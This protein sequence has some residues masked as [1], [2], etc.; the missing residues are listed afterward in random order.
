MMMPAAPSQ[1]RGERLF[2]GSGLLRVDLLYFV[3][4]MADA[5]NGSFSKTVSSDMGVFFPARDG[6][7]KKSEGN[8]KQWIV[9]P[10]SRFF[11][12]GLL[13]ACESLRPEQQ[14]RKGSTSI[15]S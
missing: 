3:E 5:N 15:P 10:L 1:G 11:T 6:F 2:F 7:P 13:G 8:Q 12:C 9:A 14:G 4:T